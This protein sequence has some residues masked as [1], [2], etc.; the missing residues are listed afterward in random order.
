MKKVR[1]FRKH[2]LAVAFEATFLG[3]ALAAAFVC[4]ILH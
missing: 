3:L 2:L 1:S 4:S